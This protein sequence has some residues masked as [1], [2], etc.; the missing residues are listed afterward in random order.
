MFVDM[1]VAIAMNGKIYHAVFADLFEHVVE[2]SQSGLDVATAVAV[3]VDADEDVG[4]LG[5]ALHFCSTFATIGDGCSVGPITNLYEA[6]ADVLGEATVGIAVANDVRVGDVVVGIV[7]VF[8]DE[9]GVGLTCGSV[10]LRE[11]RVDED[12]VELDA[13]AT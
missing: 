9:P 3:E 7:D 12:I 11:M 2:E 8:L 13:F 6:T 1:Q 5:G 10:V 4:L